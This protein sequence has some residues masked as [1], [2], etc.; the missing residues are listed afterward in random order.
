M[1]LPPAPVEYSG[2][3]RQ[4]G[5]G[6]AL[7][8]ALLGGGG[9][10]WER[11]ASPIED[12]VFGT[13]GLLV[14][15]LFL[16]AT[17]APPKETTMDLRLDGEGVRLRHPFNGYSFALPWPEVTGVRIERYESQRLVVVDA[18]DPERDLEHTDEIG[19][20]MRRKRLAAVGSRFVIPSGLFST[21][22]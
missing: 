3:R 5:F 12:R 10:Q 16:W 15:A 8:L 13:I 20:E 11:H 6:L 4:L 7:S 21:L 17:L 19:R 22:R 14:G 2:A 1:A 9:W 18:K